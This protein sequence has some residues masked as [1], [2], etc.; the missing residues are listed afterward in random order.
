MRIHVVFHV[1]LLELYHDNTLPHWVKEPPPP[2]REVTEEGV[3]EQEW[4]VKE[5]LLSH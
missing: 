2:I 4:E 3:N 5:I 1:S